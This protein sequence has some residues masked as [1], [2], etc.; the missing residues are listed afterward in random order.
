MTLHGVP[1]QNWNMDDLDN[2]LSG[3]CHVVKMAPVFINDNFSTLRV[4]V[5]CHNPVLIPATLL[6]TTNPYKTLVTVE[7]EG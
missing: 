2:L 6:M 3:I 7:L 1:L 5:A 4:L